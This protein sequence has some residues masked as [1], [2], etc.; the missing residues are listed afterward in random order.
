MIE[1]T[2]A[3]ILINTTRIVELLEQQAPNEQELNEILDIVGDNSVIDASIHVDTQITT[4]EII[5]VEELNDL[6]I[7]KVESGVDEQALTALI[8]SFAGGEMS[9][10]AVPQDCY[11]E[12]K[13]KILSL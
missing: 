7:K 9:L 5:T 3:S 1:D 12:L 11:S 6:C 10:K 4:T 13:H 8:A 2:L